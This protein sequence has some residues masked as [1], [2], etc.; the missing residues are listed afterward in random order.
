MSEETSKPRHGMSVTKDV[1]VE[2]SDGVSLAVDV[3]RPDADGEFPALLS[4]TP[5]AKDTDGG[6]IDVGPYSYETGAGEFSSIEASNPEFWTSRGYVHAVAD[7]RGCGQSEGTYHNMLSPQEGEDGYDLVEWLADQP[8]CDGNVGMVGISYLGI[9]QYLVAAEQPP[10]LRAIFPHDAWA[11]TYRDIMHHGGIK[12]TFFKLEGDIAATDAKSRSHE[13]F[14]QDEIDARVEHLMEDDEIN[15]K[16]NTVIYRKLSIPELDPISFD[17]LINRT[18]NE[19]FDE[20]SPVNRMDQIEVPT[21][22][23]SEMHKYTVSMHLPGTTWGWE[24][25]SG[26]TKLAFQPTVPRRPFLDTD[27]LHEEILRWYDYHLKGKDTGIMDEPPVKVWVRGAERFRYGEDWPLH[28]QTDWTEFHLRAGG[29]LTPESPAPSSEPPSELSYEP[30]PPGAIFASSPVGE[31]PDHLS[32]RTEP[33]DSPVEIVGPPALYLHAALSN[34]D[35]DFI[36]RV[37]DVAPDG[38][39]TALTRG[40]LKAS[41]RELDE[42]RS[43]PWRPYHPHDEPDPVTPGEVI[44]YAIDVQ[45]LANRFDAGHRLELEIWPQDWETEA[46]VE[47]QTMIWG[48]THHIP[49]GEAVEYSVYHDSAYPSHLLLPVMED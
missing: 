2:M 42:E 24:N 19:F 41:H 39:R 38:S 14:G 16:N 13:L 20:R 35:G 6:A 30:N 25:V 37:L 7:I 49:H 18:D 22:L 31:K 29:R 23:G 33:F 45:P 9:V 28:D 47:D 17:F 44:E 12:S 1:M 21:Y 34:D 27:D 46:D 10:H 8:W 32:F 11:D 26:E 48:R 43:E 5:Y 15:L 40:W 3:R 36:V 4:M